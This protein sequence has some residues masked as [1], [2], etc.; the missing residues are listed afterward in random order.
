MRVVVSALAILL[1]VACRSIRTHDERPQYFVTAT[2]LAVDGGPSGLCVA[3]DPIALS[4][5]WWWEPGRSG[6]SSRSTGPGVFH[7]DDAKVARRVR[8]A[9][10]DAHFRLPLIVR[11]DSTKPNFAE[12]NLTLQDGY[13][14]PRAHGFQSRSDAISKYPN[15]RSSETAF[16]AA[17]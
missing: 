12:V 4:G 6:C 16:A 14:Q 5:V 11:V 3:V 17:C 7:G 1:L 15:A 8:S 2:P 9:T 10:I 13:S